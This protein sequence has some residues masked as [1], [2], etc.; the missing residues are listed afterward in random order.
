PAGL[1][2]GGGRP[3][4][5]RRSGHHGPLR[6][7]LDGVVGTNPI[8]GAPGL[9]PHGSPAA[10]F[11]RR[12]LAPRGLRWRRRDLG[13]GRSTVGGRRGGATVLDQRRIRPVR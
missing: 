10:G 1:G 5:P 4:F 3:A 6:T 9:V 11:V 12:T 8:L 7:V 13:R 2:I